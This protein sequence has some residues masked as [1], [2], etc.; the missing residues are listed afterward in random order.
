M[1]MCLRA[2]LPAR[3]N[4]KGLVN[5]IT[6]RREKT[7]QAVGRR[8]ATLAKTGIRSCSTA[9]AKNVLMLASARFAETGA[10]CLAIPSTSFRTSCLPFHLV[11]VSLVHQLEPR[12]G[13]AQNAA[14]YC[15][16]SPL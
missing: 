6:G 4:T 9:K 3:P 8:R 13:K 12:D 1:P 16:Y 5:A 10:G 14:E 15:D 2:P 7:P 11:L